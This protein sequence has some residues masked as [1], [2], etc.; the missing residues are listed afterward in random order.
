MYRGHEVYGFV[1]RDFLCMDEATVA[2]D[3]MRSHRE[4]LLLF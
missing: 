1:G 4:Q 3:N 2:L